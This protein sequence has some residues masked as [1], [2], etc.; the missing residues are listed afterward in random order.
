MKIPMH[1]HSHKKFSIFIRFAIMIVYTCPLIAQNND[2]SYTPLPELSELNYDNAE[3][4]YWQM[5]ADILL[6]SKGMQISKAESR[7]NWLPLTEQFTTRLLLSKSD[8]SSAGLPAYN[9]IFY[10]KLKQTANPINLGQI[11]L[12]YHNPRLLKTL[13][14]G[15]FRLKA[16]EGLCLGSYQAS[17][18]NQSDLIVPAQG[19]SHPAL[20]G[21]A[22][23]LNLI[24]TD[25]VFWLSQTQRLASMENNR[26]TSLYE[27]SLSINATK[28]RVSERT[29]GIVAN[30]SRKKYNLGAYF[31]HRSLNYEWSDSL[32]AKAEDG[33]GLFGET[34]FKPV[35][36][37]FETFSSGDKIAKA[38]RIEHQTKGLT[39]SLHYFYRPSV[40]HLSYAK[41]EQVFGQQTGCE[42]LSWDFRYKP[43]AGLTLISRVAMVKDLTAE[44]DTHWKERLILSGVWHNQDRQCGLTYYRFR[45]DAIPLAD[46]LYADLLSIQ[47]RIKGNWNQKVAS[48]LSYALSCQYQHYRDKKLSKNGVKLNQSFNYSFSGLSVTGAFLIWS[49]QKNQ[50]QASELLDEDE[51]LAQSTA[52]S[53]FKI[54]VKYMIN[55]NYRLHIQFYR[56]IQNDAYQTLNCSVSTTF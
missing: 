6:S 21:F 56:P 2:F 3:L 29:G 28:D 15:N 18:Q 47:N 51:Y 40:Q 37:A 19:L 26:I 9:A 5:P 22:A 12:F 8:L 10:Q 50:Y 24:R 17:H 1:Q 52:G 46:T 54:S 55:N 44:A 35:T 49:N 45:K 41:T 42:E 7:F 20:T 53:A 31:Y 14:I 32:I 11:G 39:Q 4:L 34:D 38:I 30:Y 25:L 16:G 48:G 36:L 27:S 33:Y 43:A 23:R 13:A